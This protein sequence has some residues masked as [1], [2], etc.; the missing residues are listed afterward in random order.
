[1]SEFVKIFSEIKDPRQQ[2]K[3][4][5]PLIEVIYLLIAAT[6]S[7]ANNFAEIELYG[8]LKLTFLRKIFPYKNG[9][10]THETLGTI[11]SAIDPKQFMECFMKWTQILSETIEDVIAI[12]GKTI[13]GSCNENTGQTA[14]HIV[15]AWASQQRISLAQIKVNDKSNEITAIPELLNTLALKGNIVTIDAMGCQKE[16]A[17]TIIKKRQIMFWHLNKIIKSYTK[18]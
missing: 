15:S 7:G 6:I 18:M 8:K 14:L 12:D 13:R 9:I 16:V 3:I 4:L 1:M 17:R 5:Y 10:P 11:L 2:G